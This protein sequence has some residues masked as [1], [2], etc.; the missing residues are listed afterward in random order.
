MKLN[1]LPAKKP[2]SA[3]EPACEVG[4]GVRVT[5]RLTNRTLIE[6]TSDDR[7][8]IPPTWS[9]AQQSLAI[10]EW[11]ELE[12][13]CLPRRQSK[14]FLNAI[15]GVK[16][17]RD[18]EAFR[19]ALNTLIWSFG[20]GSESDPGRGAHRPQVIELLMCLWARGCL[21]WPRA[22][23]AIGPAIIRQ[24]SRAWG[25]AYELVQAAVEAFTANDLRQTKVRF[26]AFAKL[27]LSRSAPMEV[28]DICPGSQPKAL[29]LHQRSAL[30][31][32]VKAII[33]LQRAA[34]PQGESYA[35]EDFLAPRSEKRPRREDPSLAWVIA[36]EPRLD[37]WREQALA[38]LESKVSGREKRIG[39]LNKWFDYLLSDPSMPMN[40]V[41]MFDR[42]KARA[43]P[44]LPTGG[45]HQNKA[46]E[47]IRQFLDFVLERNCSVQD[48]N[49]R[50][51][52]HA[53]YRN[54]IPIPLPSKARAAF[55]THR[56]PMPTRLIRL[57]IQILMEKDHAWA[58]RKTFKNADWLNWK[59]PET[60]K[61]ERI[62]CP[63]RCYALL[64][65]LLLPARTFQVRMLD[66]GEADTERYDVA[67]DKWA[68]NAKQVPLSKA[69]TKR[70][71]RIEN[72]VFRK[73]TRANGTHGSMLFFNTNKTADADRSSGE[74]G[75]VMPWEHKEALALFS[76]LR[77]WQE[78]HNPIAVPTRWAS[79]PELRMRHVDELAQMGE[80]CFLFRD[81]TEIVNPGLPITDAKLHGMWLSLMDEAE[82]RL[83][84]SGETLADGSPIAIVTK[85]NEQ[86]RPLSALYD[87]H[88][89]RVTIITA[90][91]E[92]GV[93]PEYIMKAVG[94]SSVLMTLYYVKI[95]SEDIAQALNEASARQYAGESEQWLRHLKKVES[96]QLKKLVAANH[97]SG[98]DAFSNSG[99]NGVLTMP[100]GLCSMG[101]RRCGDGLATID[102][103]SGAKSFTAVPGLSANC[104]S[105]RFFLTG[106]AF[107]RGL[108]AH[109]ND[110]AYR[111]KDRSTAFRKAQ[112]RFDSLIHQRD[113]A[114]EERRPFPLHRE[115]QL[116]ESA[117]ERS[118]ME[119]DD[120][121][122]RMHATF[123]LVQKSLSIV[124][125][126]P[127]N[128]DGFSLVVAD[129]E[130]ARLRATLE[131][132]HELHQLQ[133]VCE[134]AVLFEGLQI[135]TKKPNLERMRF[136]DRM[137]ADAGMQP[138]FCLIQDEEVALRVANEMGRL[139]YATM[140]SKDVANLADG[141]TTLA[142]L[143]F[144]KY[145]AELAIKRVGTPGMLTGPSGPGRVE[146]NSR[147]AP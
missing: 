9:A 7:F 48:D 125:S 19:L 51:Y 29:P 43:Y 124:N 136:F 114:I 119:V 69:P 72:G 122:L 45:R 35:I 11:G 134:S 67:S 4:D 80:A 63:V 54:P 53:H 87:L 34:Q 71:A 104:V 143:G 97:D 56:Q 39:A 40:P 110:L 23:G 47:E 18:R 144:D 135:E 105:C 64:A 147:E 140:S 1:D 115:L 12:T 13:E 108:E 146:Q 113:L 98:I 123:Q 93:P 99:G 42:S 6:N 90:L 10:K 95:N 32:P 120:L 62:W 77:D 76:A 37:L 107:L 86:G 111:L 139:L 41:E 75:Y 141:R 109:F 128:D 22:N 73:Y 25:H 79:V 44:Q 50:R 58:K 121:G 138:T 83:R 118:K 57:C 82:Q 46:N 112:E 85:R 55:E 102:P 2:L 26:R 49:G 89:L 116:A 16:R 31:F 78:K 59:N 94:H 20:V 66:S 28:R 38:F 65:K 3:T 137:L 88:T 92:Q 129:G 33:A 101:G 5:S 130:A 36:K 15:D 126:H 21:I 30:L 91:Y 145:P 60:G 84:A 103:K 68:P 142:A 61:T 74:Q 96:G 100:H 52:P 106:P 27:L 14:V 117:A 8:L 132:A 24:E 127:L 70:G 131:E 81:P 133:R 17:A